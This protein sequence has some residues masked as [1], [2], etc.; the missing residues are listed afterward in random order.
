MTGFLFL[1]VGASIFA[2]CCYLAGFERG[3]R[4]ERQGF[5][6]SLREVRRQ[7]RDAYSKPIPR[8]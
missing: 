2:Y 7:E 5:L 8:H 3:A 6:P 4:R 1:T